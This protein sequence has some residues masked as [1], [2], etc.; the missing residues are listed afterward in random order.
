M[1]KM[2]LQCGRMA[3]VATEYC[4]LI[5]RGI[6]ASELGDAATDPINK[7][8]VVV[9]TD[10]LA[11]LDKL[12]PRLHV[13]VTA[14][15]IPA[16]GERGYYFYDDEQRCEMFLRLSDV[17]QADGEIW[18]AYADTVVAPYTRQQWC[19]RMADNLADMY[20][21]L[22]RG[23]EILQESP[24]RA[25]EN[26]QYSFYVHWGKHLLDAEYWLHAVASGDEPSSL[27]AWHWPDKSGLAELT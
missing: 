3:S 5:E 14:L 15:S 13:A 17:L 24:K 23:L 1:K 27:P 12:L 4:T 9:A 7:K 6:D 18:S 20:F 16:E 19:E 8:N 21:D 26:W 25:A 2:P 11:R 22:K 10:W